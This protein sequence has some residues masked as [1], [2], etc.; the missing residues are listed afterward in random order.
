LGTIVPALLYCWKD[1]GISMVPGLRFDKLIRF[2]RP[3]GKHSFQSE[4]SGIWFLRPWWKASVSVFSA[5]CLDQTA[6][7]SNHTA[8]RMDQTADRSDHIADHLNLIA[9]RL[10]LKPKREKALNFPHNVHI[11]SAWWGNWIKSI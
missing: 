7:R 8:D 6:D 9:G 1:Q 11:F 3:R 5:G 2:L 10:E 4:F